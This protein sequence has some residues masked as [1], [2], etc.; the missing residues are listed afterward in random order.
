MINSLINIGK[1]LRETGA[2]N[3]DELVIELANGIKGDK[4]TEIF[5]VDIKDNGDIET[6]SEDFYPEITAKALF[7][8][9]GN[10]AMGTGIRTD[11]FS[12]KTE[13]DIQKCDKKIKQALEYCEKEDYLQQ[14][15]EI[16]WDRIKKYGKNFFAVILVNGKYPIELFKDKFMDKMF[17]TMFNKMDDDNVCHFC[18]NTGETFNTTTF[19]FYT[20]DKEVYGNIDEKGKSGVVICKD[21]LYSLLFGKSYSD[22]YLTA[23]WMGSN[24]MF[25]PH[26]YNK[27]IKSVYESSSFND[28]NSKNFIAQ[29]ATNEAAVLRKLGEGNT[30]TDI[31][32]FEKEASKTFYIQECIKSMLP[33]RFTELADLLKKY[34]NVD[35]KYK[36]S[37]Y[38][39]VQIAAAMKI[40]EKGIESTAKEK[41][42]I[43]NSI[44]HG[45]RLNRD[46]FF[47]RAMFS[48][49]DSYFNNKEKSGFQIN[50][51]SRIYNFL[52]DSKCLKG[53]FDIMKEYHDYE[54]LFEE[55]K[56][57]FSTNEKKAWFLIGMAYN[58]INY[59]MKLSNKGEDGTIADRSSLDKNF[60]FARKFDFRDFIYFTNLLSDKV[61]KY[62]INSSWINGV[63]NTG[64]ELMAKN[65]SKLS[66]DEAKYIFFWGM[67][68]YFKKNDENN[69]DINEGEN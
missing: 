39:V 64:K 9:A 10:G 20:N 50:N 65:E 36:L 43:I 8:S 33:S 48:Y 29:I 35:S 3:D 22:K 41:M 28:E 30:E 57:Y 31:V 55:N 23:Y 17:S 27:K 2:V 1:F 37:L 38:N 54:E 52:V 44:F 25:L 68:M 47:K 62:K 24:V 15:K 56:E 58:S 59:K 34:S 45:R 21:C 67:T 63:I 19:K 18:G 5:N 69:D 4:I 46:I 6:N 14:V 16:I 53:G 7:Y 61:I 26:E 51:I 32:F 42:K 49:K 12:D 11:V 66:T 13:K 60:F 40:G